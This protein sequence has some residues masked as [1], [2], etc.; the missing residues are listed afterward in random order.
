MSKKKLL[1]L[2]Q[3]LESDLET[4]QTK[5]PSQ[6]FAVARLAERARK[7]ARLGD[8]SLQERAISSFLEVNDEVGG[9]CLDLPGAVINDAREFIEHSLWR[10]SS[11]ASE[12]NVQ[13]AL[14]YCHLLELW[15]FGPGAS[16]GTNGTH[17]AEKIGQPWTVTSDARAHVERLRRNHPYLAAKDSASG[18]GVT[19]VS[20]SRLLTVPKNEEKDRTIAVEP[21]GNMCMQLAAG[22][23]LE[24]ALRSVGLDIRHQQEKNQLLARIGSIGGCYSTIDL[25]AASDRIR[26]DLVRLLFPREWYDLL[27]ALRS[28]QTEL[29]DGRIVHLN[30]IST[31]GNGYTF[32]LMTLIFVAL[33]YAYSAQEERG[34]RLW[35]DWTRFAVF[36]DDIILPTDLYTGFSY[37]LQ[38]SGLVINHDKSYSTGPFR[39]SCGGD[40]YEGCDVTPFYVVSLDCDAEVYAAINKVVDWMGKVKV[41]LPQTIGFLLSLVDHRLLL[42]PEW[43]SDTS[44]LRCTQV[45]RRYYSLRP[46]QIFRE[47]KDEFFLMPLACAG[48][49]TSRDD[50]VLY[51]PRTKPRWVAIGSRMPQG[52][53][54]GRDPERDPVASAYAD[55]V[56]SAAR[57]AKSG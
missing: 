54:D 30:M 22:A 19:V 8:S 57:T 39:E 26:P 17:A 46:K 48:Y 16:Y 50:R 10:Y 33:L 42:V 21:L 40:Y 49:V 53:L 13:C 31:M 3:H 44:G 12:L 36:G 5:T 43:C 25:S 45:P 23:Y 52:F 11:A 6:A 37:I 27:M 24:G 28:P 47:L 55:F 35:M 18:G 32:P 20:G 4:V 38:G 41:Y 29:P 14:D 51:L 56:V 1:R 15:R 34:R 2:F 7:R 9:G